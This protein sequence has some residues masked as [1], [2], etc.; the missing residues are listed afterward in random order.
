MAQQNTSFIV[1]FT[2]QDGFC[3]HLVMRQYSL[4]LGVLT[5]LVVQF[6]QSSMSVFVNG[7]RIVNGA[8]KTI[9]AT[10]W[11]PN[12]T[13]QVFG[14]DDNVFLGH[15]LQI[16]M[17]RDIT[18]E[19]IVHLYQQGVY[20]PSSNMEPVL[21][22][23]PPSVQSVLIPQ[24]ATQ[25]IDIP[26][27]SG[28]NTGSVFKLAVQL[29]SLPKYGSLWYKNETNG[30]DRPVNLHDTMLLVG[31]ETGVTVQYK[32]LTSTY[33]NAPE[34]N[35]YGSRIDS[36]PESIV[37]RVVALDSKDSVILKSENVSVPIYVIHV[38]HIPTLSVPVQGDLVD[39]SAGEYAIVGIQF[40]DPFDFDIDLA[41]VLL[42]AKNG[43]LSL[44]PTN[45]ELADF[46]TCRYRTL[47]S[48][49]CV[50]DGYQ[51]RIMSFV[52][53]P[54]DI[55]FILRN[56]QY[57]SF[58]PGTNDTIVVSVYDG[59]GGQCL[60]QEEH[61]AY[62]SKLGNSRA[63]TIHRGCS[64]VNATILVAGY[65]SKVRPKAKSTSDPNVDIAGVPKDAL[66]ESLFWGGVAVLVLMYVL[67]CCRIPRC[68]ARGKTVV[69]D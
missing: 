11:N 58:A 41:R 34:R 66:V 39:A 9:N 7:D 45:L 64:E 53:I 67:G 49:Q 26:L 14:T 37:Y 13:L 69:P 20:Y 2:D 62:H 47:S 17:Y 60:H 28:N 35:A 22:I 29:L 3:R 1:S 50:G 40:S 33:F 27:K 10:A 36:I 46:D 5:N 25:P 4:Q 56:L 32:L 63:T 68:L 65:S 38:N 52:G 44:S 16:D 48:W 59:A 31:N 51:D 18:P 23:L 61:V 19:E 8:P 21:I 42:S 15:V 12:V 43:H 54:A 24:D 55:P 30:Q 57:T 6:N